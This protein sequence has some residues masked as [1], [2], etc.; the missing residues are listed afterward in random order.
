MSKIENDF[1][2]PILTSLNRAK[3]VESAGDI[4]K[5]RRLS[6]RRFGNLAVINSQTHNFAPSLRSEFALSS[7]PIGKN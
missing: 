2:L 4:K 6:I 3:V 5:R 7:F 1:F